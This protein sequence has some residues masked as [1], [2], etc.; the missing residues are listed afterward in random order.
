MD[1]LVKRTWAEISLKNI[2]HNYNCLRGL[3]PAGV[4]L[5]GV[6]KADSY[7]HG[8]VPVAR[9]LQ[10]LGCE[11]LAVTTIDEASELRENGVRM[12]I[13]VLSPTPAEYAG[14]LAR[15]RLTQA[16]GDIETA[17]EMSSL[18]SRLGLELKAHIK[19]ETGMG[20]TG[21]TA[22]DEGAFRELLELL[23]LPGLRAEGVFTHFAVSECAGDPFSRRQ[24]IRFSD[25]VSRLE[26]ESGHK[27]ALKHCSNSGAALNFR[28]FDLN[29]VRPGIALYGMY[30]GE[31]AGGI[32]LRPAME[33]KTRVAAITFRKAGDT[34]SYGRAYTAVR[35]IRVAVLPIGYADGLHRILSGKMEVLINSKKAPQ[36]GRICMDMCMADVTDIPECRVGDVATIFGAG[37]PAEEL[38]EKAG[39]INYEIVCSVS[40]RV[41]RVYID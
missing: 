24:Y 23:A 32:E 39:T 20:R 7:G 4:G 13:L 19:L 15:L 29:M 16:V 11:Y 10:D 5:M 34:V 31:K 18:L 37:L 27:F 41:P 2:E 28:A 35:D 30:P 12:P 25:T 3:L 21:F 40:K 17:R 14:E 26:N 33:L 22:G 36:I 8:A 6:V 38:A 9:R 1:S